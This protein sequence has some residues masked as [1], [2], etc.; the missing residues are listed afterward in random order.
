MFDLSTFHATEAI[1]LT[2]ALDIL[3]LTDDW[4]SAGLGFNVPYLYKEEADLNW[5]TESFIPIYSSKF[6]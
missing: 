5:A 6:H 1:W 3:A 2:V 4:L